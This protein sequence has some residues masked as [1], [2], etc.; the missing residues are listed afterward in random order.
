MLQIIFLFVLNLALA[1]A[2]TDSRC[3]DLVLDWGTY[4][5]NVSQDGKV[6]QVQFL[7]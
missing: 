2:Q 5:G 7:V 6:R 4:P 3:K 1:R